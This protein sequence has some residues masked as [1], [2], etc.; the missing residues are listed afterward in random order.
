MEFQKCP[1][2]PEVILGSK[3][4]N[5]TGMCLAC[6][7]V[8]LTRI[9]D[10]EAK[11]HD[12]LVENDF[13]KRRKVESDEKVQQVRG[14]MAA[15]IEGVQASEKHLPED[16]NPY[17]AGDERC[18]MWLSGWQANETRRTTAQAVAVLQWSRDNLNLLEELQRGYGYDELASKTRLIREKLSNFVDR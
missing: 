17:P 7:E 16:Q 14:F 2:H 8:R 11:V 10:L 15:E 18:V 1:A 3:I 6:V 4:E 9:A 5:N 13:V 12:L